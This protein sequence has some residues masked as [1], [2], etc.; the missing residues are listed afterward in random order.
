MLVTQ[1][2]TGLPGE[3]LVAADPKA[4]VWIFGE[5]GSP[6]PKPV[7]DTDPRSD[8]DDVQAGK[9]QGRHGG[10]RWLQTTNADA[11]RRL[12]ARTTGQSVAEHLAWCSVSRCTEHKT[13]SFSAWRRCKSSRCHR[14]SL[15]FAPSQT[16]KSIG[17][18]K[19]RTA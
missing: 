8:C 15:W 7:G 3:V 12:I 2:L 17:F 1:S 6:L 19:S 14:A 10:A 4:D 18:L 16:K 5:A 9:Q 13:A 11:L